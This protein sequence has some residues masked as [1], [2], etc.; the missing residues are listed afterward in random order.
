MYDLTDDCK[1]RIESSFAKYNGYYL[2]VII[3]NDLNSVKN[4]YPD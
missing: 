2:D 3:T 4:K 1:N